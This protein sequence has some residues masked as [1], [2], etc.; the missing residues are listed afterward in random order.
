M[1]GTSPYYNVKDYGAAGDGST[2]DTQA[3]SSAIA[4]AAPGGRPT[5]G[6]VYL[7]P[8]AY[9]VTST[10]SLPP[11][12]S[13]E[14]A[15]WNTPG[16]QANV[17]AGSWLFVPAGSA[18]SPV[19]LAGSG[20]AVRRLG[21]NV[22]DQDAKGPPAPAGP[23]VL[24]TADNTLVEDVFLYNPFGGVFINGGGFSVMR[25]VFGQP[26]NY[27]IRVDGSR[28]T[29]FIDSVHFWNYWQLGG[30][31]VGAYQVANGTAIDLYRCDNPH[32]SNV[33]VLHYNVGISLSASAAGIPHKVHLT[34]ADFDSCVI[35]A[36]VSAPGS[37]SGR[38]GLFLSNVT[39]QAPSAPGGPVGS[40][41]WVQE[42]SSYALVHASNVRVSNSGEYAVRIDAANAQFF[43][44]N[45]SLENWVGQAGFYIASAS[46]FASLG[47]G[48][49]TVGGRGQ[50]L[51]PRSQFRLAQ[52]G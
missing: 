18:F 11:A 41:I 19:T 43:G 7:P 23:M 40:G 5:G 6:T 37:A 30:S 34:N 25:R 15:G 13:L 4:A 33:F 12:V 22:P 39:T 44:E 2:D 29:N 49:S 32:I 51:Y 20:A 24:I 10:L 9:L 36:R 8:G 31:P 27:G 38:A 3:I 26:L 45:I 16:S 47:L 17:F 46:S 42:P 52:A 48:F 21:F 28:G 50:P 35:G 1:P 14:G